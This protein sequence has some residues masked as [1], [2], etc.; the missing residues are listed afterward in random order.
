MCLTQFVDLGFVLHPDQFIK[1]PLWCNRDLG[2]RGS[3]GEK[4][5]KG[6]ADGR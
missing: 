2:M 1:Q 5:V 3:R 6:T 4:G